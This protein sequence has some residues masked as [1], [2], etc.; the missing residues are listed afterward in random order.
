MAG[1][2]HGAGEADGSSA[3][4]CRPGVVKHALEQIPDADLTEGGND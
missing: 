3:S 4:A 2:F 1:A